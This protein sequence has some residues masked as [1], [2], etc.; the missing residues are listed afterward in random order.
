MLRQDIYLFSGGAVDDARLV[1][2]AFQ[3][4]DCL[5]HAIGSWFYGQEEILAIEAGDE[6]TGVLNP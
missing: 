5:G 6:F 2:V 1:T 4:G 3:E